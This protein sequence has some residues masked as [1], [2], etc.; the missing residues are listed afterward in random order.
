MFSTDRRD[1]HRHFSVGDVCAIP[2]QQEV[3]SVNR[4]EGDVRRVSR[5]LCRQGKRRNQRFRQRRH[6]VG[7]VELR[8][9]FHRRQSLARDAASE[10][11]L[12]IRKY[13]I[14]IGSKA[15]DL[16][17]ALNTSHLDSLYKGQLELLQPW[18]T[19]P[20]QRP[21]NGAPFGAKYLKPTRHDLPRS[22]RT[23][24]FRSHH[25]AANA[26]LITKHPHLPCLLRPQQR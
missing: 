7:D 20:P 18:S 4:R 3:H 2:R 5:C 25:P 23:G 15:R 16:R 11:P 26:S 17:T 21:H 22:V 12:I 6:I 1:G 8:Q 19:F 10:E 24:I 14:G 9:I 13:K